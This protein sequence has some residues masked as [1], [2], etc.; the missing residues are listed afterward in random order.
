ME[1]NKVF[2]VKVKNSETM[3]AIVSEKLVS[4]MQEYEI[5]DYGKV[6]FSCDCSEFFDNNK[7]F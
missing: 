7:S 2:L 6:D 4:L 5:L 3:H 1:M